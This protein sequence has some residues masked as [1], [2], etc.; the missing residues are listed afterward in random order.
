[1][2]LSELVERFP[3]KKVCNGCGKTMSTS[4]I[5][6]GNFISCCPDGKC[7]E[8]K[9]NE[10]INACDKEVMVDEQAIV[11]IIEKHKQEQIEDG[12]ANVCCGCIYVDKD[13]LA[14]AI[15]QNIK[16]ILKVKNEMV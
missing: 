3:E 1:M 16:G 13:I 11:K 8:H 6:E 9:H 15:A 7:S 5:K 2:K 4:E 10:I 14:G 12:C